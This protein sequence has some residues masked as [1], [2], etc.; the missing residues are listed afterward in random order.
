MTGFVLTSIIK[1]FTDKS[2]GA[3]KIYDQVW[4]QLPDEDNLV[5]QVNNYT[6]RSP[7]AGDEVHV[8]LTKDP[9][10]FYRLKLK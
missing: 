6:G 4:V 8:V 3:T 7:V 9:K 1:E 10:G 5:V 2:T